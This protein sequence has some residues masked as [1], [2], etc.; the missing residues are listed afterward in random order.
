[1]HPIEDMLSDELCTRFIA[2]NPQAVNRPAATAATGTH[3]YWTPSGKRM[4]RQFAEE[5]A[6][7]DDV[8]SLADALRALR[9]YVGLPPDGV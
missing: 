9:S 5:T 4:L 2:S 7:I 6:T 8:R 1:V 3:R